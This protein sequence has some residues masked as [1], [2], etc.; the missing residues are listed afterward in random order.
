[1]T[2]DDAIA[3]VDQ[4][5]QPEGLNDLQTS[6]FRHCWLGE[7]YQEIAD[8]LG[9]DPGYVRTVGSRL[10]KQLS[11][12]LDKKVTKSNLHTVFEQQTHL[13]EKRNAFPP[14]EHSSLLPEFP[15]LPLTFQSPFYLERFPIEQRCCQ[16]IL[17]PGAL[18][19]IQSPKQMGKTSLLYQV[20]GYARTQGYQTLRISC[21][22]ATTESFSDLNSFLRWLCQSMTRKLK[23]P[24]N[25]DAYWNEDPSFVKSN[26]TAYVEDYLLQEVKVPLVIGLDDVER[27]FA[28]PQIA[29]D[30]FPLLRLWHEEANETEIWQNLRLVVVHSTEVYVPLDIH[31]S[32]F[33][34][35]LPI[36][37][38]NWC[39]EQVQE[40]ALRYNLDWASGNKG[41]Q[42]LRP[43]LEMVG[44][45]PYL[46]QLA[47][48]HLWEYQNEQPLAHLEA[49]LREAP[50]DAGIYGSH[51]R[52]LLK[53]LESSSE[54]CQAMT[55]VIKSDQPIAI[56]PIAA[57]KLQS[58][59]LVELVGNL[60]TIRYQLYYEYFR[61]HLD[62]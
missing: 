31:Q 32:P 28:Y 52:R 30:F 22:E 14:P 36:H 33:N 25:L 17:Q 1:M 56:P 41:E 39:L 46:I 6:L 10:W 44:G 20:L 61:S 21:Q 47:L 60:V 26:C 29:Q 24:P 40:L 42:G 38:H 5:L 50:T 11:D 13:L 51:L 2:V 19:R 16:K 7:G 9:Y 15:S 37:L 59:G 53:I 49:I 18:I 58:M 35:G 48:Y 12:I 57:Y 55:K 43:L 34:V 45:H 8:K 4:L 27:I 23:L 54:L 3:L 62:H